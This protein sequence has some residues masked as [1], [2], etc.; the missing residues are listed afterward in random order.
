MAASG[1]GAVIAALVGNSF[2]TVIKFV[3]FAYSGSGAMMS[4]AIHSLADTGNQSLLYLGVRR[5]E[6]QADTMFHYG[7]GAERFLFALLSAV[8]IF[9]L[10]CGVTI[11]HGIHTLIH[12][13]DL[14]VSW[15][16]F[17]VLGVS[18]LLDGAVLL[19]AIRAISVEKGDK[20]GGTSWKVKSINGRTQ[21]VLLVDEKTGQTL[22]R[23]TR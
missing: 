9:I 21:V 17:A 8:G 20:V 5:S 16:I 13:P 6:K 10:G 11:Y 23:S 2:L 14:T 19:V 4:E 3:A 22:K 1:R 12:P 7:Y 15:I 18:F